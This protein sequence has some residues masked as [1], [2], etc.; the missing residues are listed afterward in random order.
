MNIIY[1]ENITKRQF[2]K[3]TG[4]DSSIFEELCGFSQTQY[5]K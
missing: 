5:M 2:I 4:F 1:K 3:N